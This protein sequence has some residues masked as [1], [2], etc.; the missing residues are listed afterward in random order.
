MTSPKTEHHAGK[1]SRLVPM[2]PELRPYL[3]EAWDAAEE[4]QEY[5]VPSNTGK[6]PRARR[7]AKLQPADP[8]PADRQAGRLGAMAPAVPQPAGVPGNRT[9]GGHP[10][11]VVTAW[12]GNTPGIALKHY[13]QVTEYRLRKRR[14]RIRC[15]LQIGRRCRIRCSQYPPQVRQE[16]TE[17]QAVPGVRLESG[18]PWR[19]PAG[20]ISGGDRIRTCD[21]EVM[22]R[23]AVRRKT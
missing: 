12:L 7:V 2:F 20:I 15:T 4:G 13:L 6:R 22:R 17:P 16:T 14:C 3:E 10:M 9:G 19:D 11:H 5:V 18:E 8:I 21:L 23:P 1:A